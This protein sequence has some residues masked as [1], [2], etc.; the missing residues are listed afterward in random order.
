MFPPAKKGFRVDV[1]LAPAAES[2]GATREPWKTFRGRVHPLYT[3]GP[4][5]L[6]R[7]DIPGM[8]QTMPALSSTCDAAPAEESPGAA[9]PAPAPPPTPP[10]AAAPEAPI[11]LED[12]ADALCHGLEMAKS[13]YNATISDLEH[14]QRAG[15]GAREHGIL[16]RQARSIQDIMRAVEEARNNRDLRGVKGGISDALVLLA[17]HTT[18]LVNISVGRSE[19]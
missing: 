10:P 19:G 4:A 13:T 14:L 3:Y 6:P 11:G 8:M 12:L 5:A 1:L 16:S 7:G 17:T 18:E 9:T 2:A 15:M